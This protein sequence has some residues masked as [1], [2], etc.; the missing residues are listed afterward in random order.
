[1]K[2]NYKSNIQAFILIAFV[3]ISINLSANVYVSPLGSNVWTGDTVDNMPELSQTI[4]SRIKVDKLKREKSAL[5]SSIDGFLPLF[6]SDGSFSDLHYVSQFRDDGAVLNHLV[7]LREMGIAYTQAGN[8]YFENDSIYSK[9]IKGLELWYSKHWIDS[10]WWQNRINHPQKLGETFIA[11]HG[12]KSDIRKEAIFTSLVERWKTEMGDPDYPNDP[13][14]AGANKCDIAMHWI[15]RGCLTLNEEVL[16]KGADRS[17]LIIVNS[18]GE[19]LQHDWSYR[20]HGA[21]LYIGGYGG[22]FIQLVTKQAYYLAGTKYSLPKDKLAI[23]SQF[24]RNTYLSV[25]RGKRMS[26][27]TLGRGVTRTNNTNQSGFAGILGMLKVVDEANAAEYENAIARLTNLQP[28]SY[29]IPTTQTHFYRSEYTLQQRPEYTFDIRMASKRMARSEYDIKE[30]KQGFFMSDGATGIYVDGEEYGTILPFWNWKKIPGTTVP[31]LTTMR[32]ADSY[33]FNGLSNFAGGVTDGKWGVTAFDML[34]NQSL[35][36]FNDDDGYSGTPNNKGTRLAALN[37]GTKKSWFIFDNEIVCLGSGIYSG[38]DENML[39]TINQC[40]LAGNT[41]V[42]SQNSDQTIQKGTFTYNA[43]DWVLNDK[44]AYYFPT[45]PE[46]KVS[47]ETKTG[48]WNNI[49]MNGSTEQLNGEVFTLWMDH[50]V[51]PVNASYVYI[52]VPNVKT[53]DEAKAYQSSTIEILANNDSVQVVH[54]KGLNVYGL[55]FFRAC[56]FVNSNIKVESSAGCVM[57]VKNTE[58]NVLSVTIADPQKQSSPINIGIKTPNLNE[59]K[60]IVYQNPASPHQGK[61]IEFI[62]D[63]STPKY[64]GREVKLLRTEWNITAS[65]AGPV[66]AAVAVDGDVPGYM[67]DGNLNSSF[68]FVKPGKTYGGITVAADAK[69][70]F[71]IDLKQTS[72]MTFLLYRHRD[73]NNTSSYL[74]ASKGSFYGKNNES[75]AF[76]PILENFNLPTD[77]TEVRIDLPSKVA[78]RFVKFVIEAWDTSSG[79]TIQLSEFNLGTKIEYPDLTNGITHHQF[80]SNSLFSSIYPNPAKAGKTVKIKCPDTDSN[81][82]KLFIHTLSGVKIQEKNINSL[83]GEFIIYQPGLYILEL[84]NNI[85][86]SKSKLI[87]D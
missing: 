6:Q 21:Q 33:I 25:I 80:D 42:S 20:Q 44:V 7:R 28:A 26:F 79:S 31:D 30:N 41:V 36:A 70:N 18:T 55:T 59:F 57:L 51:R 58:Q 85:M 24:V 63:N 86:S 82:Y 22:A 52:I 32:R 81:D 56:K 75:D 45:K 73:F 72:E 29:E 50:G 12:A 4:L 23:L 48:S 46:I 11:L 2:T 64:E 49:N 37:F 60:K 16:A 83:S 74:R 61:S 8:K 78:Y 67:I 53:V 15:Y 68:L 39:T 84:K 17:F 34:N 69:P 9:I 40:R 27:S 5:E 76:Q 3:F 54:H 35:F 87:V 47:N 62:V 14:T 19:G 38:H 13:T 71:V 66:D 77:V 1:M 10:N 43:V 65:S